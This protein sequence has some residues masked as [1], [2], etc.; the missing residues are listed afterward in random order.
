MRLFSYKIVRDYGFAPNPFHGTCTLAACKP[1]IRTAACPGDIIV[2]CGSAANKL[3]GKI[4]CILRVT[5]K[6][7]FQEYWDNPAF[8][9]KQPFFKG[10]QARAYGDNI[11]HRDSHGNWLQERSHHSFPD[12]AVNPENLRRDT[13]SDNVLWS[14]DFAYWGRDAILIPAEFRNFKGDDLYPN[15]R[16]HRSRFNDGFVIALDEWF[17][18]QPNRGY[19]G[20]PAAWP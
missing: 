7:A 1:Q 14:N 3:A 15:N 8:A 17:K 20:R 4:I 18:K 9:R 19:L 16:A 2:G 13:G 10:N 5:G 11:Y 6:C 12:G